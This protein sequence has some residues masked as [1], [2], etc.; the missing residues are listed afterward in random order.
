MATPSIP[1]ALRDRPELIG[2]LTFS[3]VVRGFSQKYRIS[4]SLVVAMVA[5]PVI[6]ML[7]LSYFANTTAT[8]VLYKV[9]LPAA[10]AAFLLQLTKV[11]PAY[12]KLYGKNGSLAPRSG[13]AGERKPASTEIHEAIR[14]GAITANYA[15]LKWALE[16][17]THL[18]GAPDDPNG[19]TPLRLAETYG[20]TRMVAMVNEA[21]R[22]NPAPREVETKQ[23]S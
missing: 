5:L 16:V 21:L 19:Q 8:Q 4:S 9:L 12:S 11:I 7:G 13:A 17:N 20:N 3:D 1:E 18:L 15:W 2:P 10:G 14:A 6:G 22:K 23:D